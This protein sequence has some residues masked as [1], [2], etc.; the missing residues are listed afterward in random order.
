MTRDQ[1]A[2]LARAAITVVLGLAP[3][4]ALGLVAGLPVAAAAYLALAAVAGVV[5]ARSEWRSW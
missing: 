1:L 3:F 4:V 2:A 5:F